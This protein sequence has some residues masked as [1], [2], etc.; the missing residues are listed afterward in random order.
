MFGRKKKDEVSKKREANK[1]V[2]YKK[3]GH[4]RSY[5][6]GSRTFTIICTKN[7]NVSHSHD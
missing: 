2:P 5:N 1:K 4:K 3:C 6:K 7:R